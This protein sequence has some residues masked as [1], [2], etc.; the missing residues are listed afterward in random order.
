MASN[1]ATMASNNKPLSNNKPIFLRDIWDCKKIEKLKEGF[2]CHWCNT[3]YKK[4]GANRAVSH[5]SGIKL[6]GSN[7]IKSCTGSIPDNYKEIYMKLANR[8]EHTRNVKKNQH[9]MFKENIRKKNEMLANDDGEKKR[10]FN[11]GI[12]AVSS[13]ENTSR[14]STST[15]Y[16][17][18]LNDYY[19]PSKSQNISA[20][21]VLDPNVTNPTSAL[22][23]CYI[24]FNKNAGIFSNAREQMDIYV[25]DFI[26]SKG[27]PF[28]IVEDPK[29]QL[30]VDHAQNIPKNYTLPSRY[31]VSNSLLD[32]L[33]NKYVT[34]HMKKLKMNEVYYGL[35]ILGDGATIHKK[36]LFNI[37]VSGAFCPTYVS[38]VYDCTKDLEI[39]QNK[40]AEFIARLFREV[41]YQ[42]DPGKTL[43]DLILVDGASNV[44]KGGE[45]LAI[46]FPR[47]TVMHGCE[48]VLSLFCSDLLKKTKVRLLVIIYRIIYRVFGSGST[49]MAYA[50]FQKHAKEYNKNN[51]IGLIRASGT[52]MGGYFYAFHRLLRLYHPL[53]KAVNSNEWKND[54]SLKNNSLKTLVENI[55]KYPS[56]FEKIKIIVLILYP[57]IKTLRLS[58]S[59]KPGMDKIYYYVKETT[60]YINAMSSTFDTLFD[61]EFYEDY[62]NYKDE[63]V[64]NIEEYDLDDPMEDK[65]KGNKK[66]SDESSIILD[67]WSR[68]ADA[69]K[70]PWTI[71]GYLLSIE[72]NIYND[73][74]FATKEDEDCLR[75][76]AYKL[77]SHFPPNVRDTTV[78]KCMEQ[79]QLFRNK[80]QM[81]ATESWWSSDYA[82]NGESHMWHYTYPSSYYKELSYVACR[83]T[84]KL[85][86]IGS[87]ER[88]WGDVKHTESNKRTSLLSSRL[89][90]QSILYGAHCLEMAKVKKN[91]NDDRYWGVEDLNDNELNMELESYVKGI[92]YIPPKQPIQ[93]KDTEDI[94]IFEPNMIMTK[95]F[96]AYLE[97]D[98]KALAHKYTPVAQFTLLAKYGSMRIMTPDSPT[99]YVSVISTNSLVWYE[100]DKEDKNAPYGWFCVLVPKGMEYDDDKCMEYEHVPVIGAKEDYENLHL[101]IAIC[102]QLEHIT[103]IDK[104][105]DKIDPVEYYGFRFPGCTYP[106]K[107]ESFPN[108][109]S[110]NPSKTNQFNKKSRKK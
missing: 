2:K 48:H 16:Q 71:A 45:L 85:L 31:A 82:I 84:S 66:I 37:L 86:G 6:Y 23:N 62:I 76:V 11:D 74:Q 88:Q 39:G 26:Y 79:Y 104:N 42:V 35:S 21:A 98:E 61:D 91:P 24:T 93:Y 67:L 64:Q 69:L 28:S 110:I 73:A 33:Y 75:E 32:K 52:R 22:T 55:I 50:V 70:T 97:D 38:R 17:L 49:H 101:C 3:T 94:N 27:L 30:L 54:V 63:E 43:L 58:D 34:D 15:E 105:D 40:S 56:F 19:D 18:S 4:A 109:V 68:R 47:V 29:F 59:N 107:Y 83:V 106:G 36:P 25:A 14:S 12:A 81:Y 57:V 89:E 108:S 99:P 96:K 72:I 95:I 13:Q 41:A 5:V 92:E 78:N 90:K 9:H 20:T 51:S 46:E 77:Y 7:G 44:Q 65:K 1:N 102:N 60:K 103:C 87:C 8:K 100:K 53:L 80:L 10:K